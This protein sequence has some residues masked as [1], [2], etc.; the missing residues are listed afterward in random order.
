MIIVV[1]HPYW[2]DS[3]MHLKCTDCLTEVVDFVFTSL[4]DVHDSNVIICGDFND[5]RNY[6]ELIASLSNTKPVVHAP[7]RGTNMLDQ[8]FASSLVPAFQH[9]SL[10]PSVPLIITL[11]SGILLT[12]V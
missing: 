10:L 4:L 1:Y 11:S 5:L 2:N 7:T 6:Y 3:V 8:I 9:K 12:P